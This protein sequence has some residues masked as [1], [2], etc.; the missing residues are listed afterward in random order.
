MSFLRV[1]RRVTYRSLK[2][3]Y[4]SADKNKDL[5]STEIK[6]WVD[7]KVCSGFSMLQKNPNKIFGQAN[8]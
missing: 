1:F 5:Y 6:Y 3:V 8:T 7:Q 4:P 2:N